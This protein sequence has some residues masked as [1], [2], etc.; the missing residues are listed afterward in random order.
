MAAISYLIEVIDGSVRQRGFTTQYIIWNTNKFYS[1][2]GE[3][4]SWI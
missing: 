3:E 2:R 4:L 1:M